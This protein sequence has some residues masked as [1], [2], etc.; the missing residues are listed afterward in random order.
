MKRAFVRMP[1]GNFP[2]NTATVPL[3]FF[4]HVIQEI[5]ES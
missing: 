1:S 5:K 2:D 3:V 4:A